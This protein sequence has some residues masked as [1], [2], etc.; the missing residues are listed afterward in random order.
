MLYRQ[1]QTYLS[2]PR[3]RG[4]THGIASGGPIDYNVVTS[5]RE[6]T[7]APIATMHQR[8]VHVAFLLT[9]Y[10]AL[11]CLFGMPERAMAAS[12]GIL[13][14]MAV[15]DGRNTGL[16]APA[17]SD[18][19][20]PLRIV[21][22]TDFYMH[23]VDALIQRVSTKVS[24][25]EVRRL[26]R[27]VVLEIDASNTTLRTITALLKTLQGIRYIEED[28]RLPIALRAI[29]NDPQYNEQWHLHGR[30]TDI[31]GATAAAIESTVNGNFEQAWDTIRGNATTPIA[32]IDDGFDLAH[33]D[34]QFLPGFDISN[35]AGEADNDPSAAPGDFHGT[36]TAGTAAAIGFNGVGVTGACPSCPIIPVRLIGR[37]GPKTLFTTGS[38]A[39]QA[40]EFAVNAGA[41]V[42]NN[43]WGPP[44][45]NPSFPQDTR[46]M[47][48]ETG[49]LPQVLSEA[50]TY[51]VREGRD[52]LG[53]VV[54][55][56]S[57]NGNES[58]AYDRLAADRRVLSIGSL[59]PHGR[60][61]SYSDY[62]PTLFA[63]TASSDG[64]A[65]PGIWT[66]DISGAG[67]ISPFDITDAYGGTSAS[68][69]VAAGIVA[70]VIAA[71]PDLYAAQVIEALAISAVRVNAADFSATG[72]GTPASYGGYN[73]IGHS[74]YYGYGRLDAAGALERAALY[75]NDCTDTFELCGNDRDDNCDGRIDEDCAPCVPDS[76][77]ELC[78]D[79]DN[80]C[81]GRNNEGL[82]CARENRPLCAPCDTTKECA[83]EHRCRAS[84]TEPGTFCLALCPEKTTCPTGFACD[85][86]VCQLLA[87]PPLG[88]DQRGY[89][90]GCA[91]LSICVPEICDGFD[92]N[93][94]GIIDN[95]DDEGQEARGQQRICAG[96]G[97]CVS[98]TALCSA[99]VWTCGFVGNPP[100]DFEETERT[101]DGR[102]NDCDGQIDEPNGNEEI[103]GGCACSGQAGTNTWPF[104][105]C[106]LIVYQRR[107]KRR[108]I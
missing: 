92:N 66:T 60:R 50:L 38:A 84:A 76:G 58:I 1:Q 86:E 21:I 89:F 25:H 44:D 53:A 59:G 37:G 83:A 65:S 34:L 9:A 95:V 32:I 29:P 47:V 105:L 56:S 79:H 28:A 7:Q 74:V 99:G 96:A 13:N 91:S 80:N 54:I 27:A 31:T 14:I 94:D 4:K 77:N 71:Y 22:G 72:T 15:K 35:D 52:G 85:G 17:P 43:S 12:T 103:C 107:P 88:E 3:Q 6:H 87:R 68:A 16:P 33:P 61:A 78:D 98:R 26:R 106:V 101:C 82:V 55:W 73:A 69:A 93:C 36:W 104:F 67:G 81:D 49:V 46:T 20:L 57:G 64:G 39:A 75:T 24:S 18:D 90:P 70:L 97:I 108:T 40:I 41:V 45:G 11:P 5:E 48:P 51:A 102:D 62:G 8:A 100:I 10:A 19:S 30:R 42:I 2:F 63:V 23:N